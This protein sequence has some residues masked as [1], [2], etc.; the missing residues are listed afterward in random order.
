MQ[1]D[2]ATHP[3]TRKRLASL[4]AAES[5]VALHAATDTD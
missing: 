1:H 3:G 5:G 2:S 4:R